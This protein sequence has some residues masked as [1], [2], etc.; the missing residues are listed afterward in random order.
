MNTVL[1]ADRDLGFVFWLGQALGK[2]GYQVL[3]AM[4]VPQAASYA[5]QFRV[6][7]LVLDPAPVVDVGRGADPDRLTLL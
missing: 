6:D 2:L 5:E 4:N 1:I 3:P 7:L